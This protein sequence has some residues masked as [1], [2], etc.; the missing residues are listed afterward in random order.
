MPHAIIAGGGIGGLTAA[1]CLHQKGWDIQLLEQ[2]PALTE[3]GAGIQI[4]PNGMKVLKQIG[5][6]EAVSN[7]AFQPD[8]TELRIGKTG[9][10][11]FSIPTKEI[12]EQR[13]GA[14]YLQIHRADLLNILATALNARAPGA[15]QTN[16]HVASY[17]Q[18]NGK[19]VAILKDGAELTGD[20]LIGADG[21]HS[22][23]RQTMQG[24]DAPRFT[25]NVAWRV[26][27][28]TGKL[29]TLLPPKTGC[30]W[31]GPGRHA[32][33]YFLRQG[34]LVNLV[35]IVERDDW[36]EEGWTI[37]GTRKEALED[38][39]DFHP[40]IQNILDKADTHYRWALHDRKPLKQWTDGPIALMGDAC[41]PM[42]PFLAQGAVQAIE[43][44]WVL[45][46]Q[47]ANGENIAESLRTY[48]ALRLPRT[49]NVQNGAR[50]NM[51]LFHK[52]G[53]L[54]QFLTY[55]PMKLAATFVPS[56]INHRMDWI[57][58]HDVVSGTD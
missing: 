13:W 41:H 43:D 56:Y 45:A 31:V 2:A 6:D 57:Y 33:T 8:G 48:Q 50:A 53:R 29:G 54:Q 4:S 47:V 49:A 37:Q 36:Q 17:R 23:I 35:G 7:I 39:R 26:V 19:A 9:R 5:I 55:G 52:R 51:G 44:A 25:G 14:P 24:N 22:N 1:L 30:A 15:V 3:M 32:V 38:F 12:A 42:L 34:K 20:L 21:I 27:V 58:G 16:A 10:T 18:E 40:V 46:E 11:I 28:P